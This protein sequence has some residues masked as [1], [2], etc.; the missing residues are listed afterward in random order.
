M[1]QFKRKIKQFETMSEAINTQAPEYGV[2]MDQLQKLLTKLGTMGK[3]YQA[4]EHF[5]GK[6]NGREI[7]DDVKI[8]LALVKKLRRG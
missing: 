5:V 1:S 7:T 8:V 6:D 3:T 2:H 4:A